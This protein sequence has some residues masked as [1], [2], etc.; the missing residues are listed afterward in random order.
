ML[1]FSSLHVHVEKW[2]TGAVEASSVELLAVL[3]TTEGHSVTVEGSQLEGRA[4]PYE[5]GKVNLR[6]G[7]KLHLIFVPRN[8]RLETSGGATKSSRT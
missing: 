6:A 4:L 2:R 8:E 5:K 1:R 7:R 3:K